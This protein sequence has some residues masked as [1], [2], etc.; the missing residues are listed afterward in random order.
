MVLG[1]AR[2]ETD[3][4]E[5]P[6]VMTYSFATYLLDDSP[7]VGKALLVLSTRP[8]ISANNTVKLRMGSSLNFWV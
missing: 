6:Q 4:L 1:R 7:D 2:P 5:T 8:T 3:E